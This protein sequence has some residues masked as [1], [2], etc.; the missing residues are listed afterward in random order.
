MIATISPTTLADL[1]RKGEKV[2]LIDVRT[3]AEYGE[4]HVDFAHNIPLDRLD[5]KAVASLGGNGPLY[6]VCKSGTRSQ[7]ACEKLMAAG[8]TDVISVEGGTAACEAAGVPVVRGRKVMSLER[9]VRIAAGALVAVGAALAAFGPDLMWQ[10]IGA[11]LAGF[12]GCGL[13]FAGITDTCGMAMLIAR[14]PWN[15]ACRT[16]TTCSRAVLLG[17]VLG[18][19]CGT[20]VAEHTT[21]SLD[22]VKQAVRDQKAVIIDV[23]EPDEWQQ[24]H[25]AGAGLL[26]LSALERG[27]SPQELAKIL[28]NDKI[29]YCYCLAGGR[30][31]EAAAMLKPLGYDVRAIKP[32]YPQLVKAGFPAVV[33]K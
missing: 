18:A 11:G 23:R 17:L 7:K 9:Q 4:V 14:M 33:G 21:D 25:L 31:E 2:T 6:F 26:P 1:R 32:G 30:C 22:V 24:G 29:I 3:P 19:A 5:A 28:P 15:Q 10:R 13:V 20:A 27:V 8:L 16:A 12:V